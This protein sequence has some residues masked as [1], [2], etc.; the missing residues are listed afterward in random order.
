[1]AFFYATVIDRAL[2]GV[3]QAILELAGMKPGQSV[4]DVCCGTGDQAERFAR[5]GLEAYGIDLD[6][7]MVDEAEKRTR[8]YGKPNLHL[9]GADATALPFDDGF[10]D[11]A[12]ISMALHEKPLE[13]Q[14]RVVAEMRR[15]T[16]KGGKL[17]LADFNVPARLLFSL[18]EMMVGGEHY[19]NFRAYQASGGL[20]KMAESMALD[21]DK[22]GTAIGGGI[23]LFKINNR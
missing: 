21:I 14:K 9:Q 10:F 17:I 20:E 5:L 19:A 16:K 18:V 15:V 1:M 23:L 6:P 2:K 12:T 11:Y 13:T 3:R 7:A 4:L 8:R 22:R